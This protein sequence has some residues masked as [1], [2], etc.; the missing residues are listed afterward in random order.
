[1]APE[2]DGRQMQ[3]NDTEHVDNVPLVA[4][5]HLHDLSFRHI[6]HVSS[7]S[8]IMQVA[9]LISITN[10]EC[11]TAPIQFREFCSLVLVQAKRTRCRKGS[12]AHYVP[13]CFN[14][15]NFI[16]C[17]GLLARILI[18]TNCNANRDD[19]KAITGDL[20]KLISNNVHL[21]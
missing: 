19:G 21:I 7:S 4:I 9:P 1:M 5:C 3:M 2:F 17:L 11:S 14:S 6:P 16:K 12:I 20:T 18:S 13:H 8:I 15:N 10:H